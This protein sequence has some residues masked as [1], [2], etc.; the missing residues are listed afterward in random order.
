MLCAQDRQSIFLVIPDASPI[1]SDDRWISKEIIPNDCK[2]TFLPLAAAFSITLGGVLFAQ[3]VSPTPPTGE[4]R[5]GRH[6]HGEML[7][8]KLDP[9]SDG[10]ITQ[11]EWAGAGLATDLFQ[12]FDSNKSGSLEAGEVK[13]SMREI[14]QAFMGKV[15]SEQGNASGT[16]EPH[17]GWGNASGTPLTGEHRGHRGHHGKQG[18]TTAN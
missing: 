9:N 17:H 1:V 10:I 14:H 11:Q 7:M 18:S 3:T 4:G 8:Q 6:Q 16:F 15:R 5:V 13:T 2:K 12:K